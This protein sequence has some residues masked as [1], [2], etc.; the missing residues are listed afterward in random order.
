MDRAADAR[1]AG[2]GDE[3]VAQDRARAVEAVRALARASSVLERSSP[4]LS[5]AHYRVLSAIAQ[6][7]ERASNIARKLAVGKPTVST[8]VES[9]CRRR[10]LVRSG[11][12]G[13]QRAAALHLTPA[14]EALLQQV[15]TEM[16][17]RINDLCDRT[18]DGGRLI[19]SLVWLGAAMDSRLADRL[20]A[21]RSRTR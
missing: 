7:N 1:Q 6:G 15:E 19:E 12:A 4:D 16:I 21:G 5:L 3:D 17:S 11:V 10:L 18:P 20:A 13:D 8:A 14:G 2:A 9:L